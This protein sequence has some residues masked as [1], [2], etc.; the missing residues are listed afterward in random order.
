MATPARNYPSFWFCPDCPGVGR[1]PQSCTCSL[2]DILPRKLQYQGKGGLSFNSASFHGS[3]SQNSLPR[4]AW[5]VGVLCLLF[6]IPRTNDR[7]IRSTQKCVWQVSH[8]T[9][10]NSAAPDTLS[11]QHEGLPGAS[12]QPGTRGTRFPLQTELHPGPARHWPESQRPRSC[13]QRHACGRVLVMSWSTSGS[14]LATPAQ[15][16]SSP[17]CSV[18]PSHKTGPRARQTGETK[19]MWAGW[20]QV[21]LSV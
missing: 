11:Y 20:A 19:E 21:V 5:Q 18:H 14:A 2:L 12:Q 3:E 4:A 15:A 13:L 6:L 16:W 10:C 8:S 9:P 1:G 7:S 17:L